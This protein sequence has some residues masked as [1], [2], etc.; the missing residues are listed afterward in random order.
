LTAPLADGKPR[1]LRQELRCCD[2]LVRHVHLGDAAL[3]LRAPL[4]AA[5]GRA[6]CCVALSA[7]SRRVLFPDD[8]GR[9]WRVLVAAAATTVTPH[10]CSAH[11]A[12]SALCGCDSCLRGDTACYT[13]EVAAAE[14]HSSGVALRL[15]LAGR[16]VTLLL[17]HHL[18]GACSNARGTRRGLASLTMR[19]PRRR[20]AVP[21]AA[22]R[23]ARWRAAHDTACAPCAARRRAAGAGRLHAHHATRQVRGCSCPTS[24]E[25]RRLTR[26]RD[27]AFSPLAVPTLPL[28]H[29]PD[30]AALRAR[31]ERA[32][33]SDALGILRLHADLAAK[34]SPAWPGAKRRAGSAPPD[35]LG[36]ALAAL[37]PGAAQ[38]CR[39]SV[40]E[41]L[42]APA[43]S[44]LRLAAAAD[45]APQLPRAPP[46]AALR[47][48]ACAAW[49]A[50]GRAAPRVVGGG[51]Y[52]DMLDGAALVRHV[53][54]LQSLLAAAA[55]DA[56]GSECEPAVLLAWAHRAAEGA[57]LLA[58]ASGS[59]EAAAEGRAAGSGD[60]AHHG[61]CLML[62]R[63]HVIAEGARDAHAA[64]G[65][66]ARL[67]VAFNL[68]DAT[69]I[70][71]LDA[72]PPPPPRWAP[73][74]AAATP[75]SAVTP[76]LVWKR[77][78]VA[79]QQARVHGRVVGES[80]RTRPHV[81]GPLPPGAPLLPPPQW[82]ARLR[83]RDAAGRDT[84]D[85]YLDQHRCRLPPGACSAAVRRLPAL[86]CVHV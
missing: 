25:A 13:A 3:R 44:A 17:T 60:W 53:A 55:S 4:A 46:L 61:Q 28:L 71:L 32:C 40:Y 45:A 59:L 52:G 57:W 24:M 70:A 86:T 43:R 82:A 83:L 8:P 65:A 69:H 39:G 36:A 64:G 51:W 37:A 47:A 9:R 85:V 73:P 27:S 19:L 75:P 58:D 12:P 34:Q 30:A 78:G 56:G 76:L 7:L 74:R 15:R 41:E 16:L 54:P 22:A 20:R 77:D 50:H 2:G 67:Y 72:A 84:I 66:P 81:A 63:G 33:F 26:R 42:F 21:V 68:L 5:A 18:S 31:C 49:T 80:L 1:L 29:A 6:G 62:R 23:R 48:A 14:P 10:G 35:A 11:A 38:P 79:E